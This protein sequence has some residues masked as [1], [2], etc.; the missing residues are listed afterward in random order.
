MDVASTAAKA[1]A[2]GMLN[3]DAT[4]TADLLTQVCDGL[5][6]ISTA[7]QGITQVE[8]PRRRLYGVPPLASD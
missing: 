4:L 6:E 8:A 5:A 2:L 1:A 3:T 7:A